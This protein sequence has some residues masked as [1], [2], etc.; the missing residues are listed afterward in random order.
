MHVVIQRYRVRLGEVVDAAHYAEKWFLPLVREIPGF[1]A[2]YLVEAGNG[3][4]AS[5]GLFETQAAADKA[6]ELAHAWFSK[7]WGSFRQLP[8]EVIA[9]AVLAPI[10]ANEQAQTTGRRWLADRRSAAT[11]KASGRNGDPER[12]AGSERRRDY[13]RRADFTPIVQQQAAG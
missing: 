12:R 7:E 1:A 2:C 4:L 11:L 8:P 3:V 10:V 6:S 5:V 9:G 13:D